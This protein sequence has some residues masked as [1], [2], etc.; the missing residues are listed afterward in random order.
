MRFRAEENWGDRKIK[1]EKKKN[2]RERSQETLSGG[3]IKDYEGLKP[4]IDNN[5]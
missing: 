1:R 3:G 5:N 2:V 4:K